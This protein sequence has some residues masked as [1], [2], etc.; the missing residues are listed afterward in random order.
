MRS[1]LGLLRTVGLKLLDVVFPEPVPC[2]ACQRRRG[3]EPGLCRSCLEKIARAVAPLCNTCGRPVRGEADVCRQCAARR[4]FFT[5]ARAPT[6]YDGAMKDYIHRFKY[7]SE[8]ELGLA[9]GVLLGRFLERERTLWPVDGIVPVPLHPQRL[10]D[11]G[12]NQAEVLAKVAGD[13]VGRPVWADALQ[14]TRTTETQTRLSAR[15]RRD[16]V[17]GAFRP[18]RVE[19]PAGKHVLLVD[20]VLTSGATADEAA[21]TLLKA[22]ALSVNVLCLA[23]GVLPDEWNG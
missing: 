17:K 9:L 19:K 5:V 21:R 2:P 15:E 13:W 12:F 10:E 4:R 14:R 20:D 18:W 16:N 1:T 8:R 11:R 7:G 3:D 23:V 6:V 22:G